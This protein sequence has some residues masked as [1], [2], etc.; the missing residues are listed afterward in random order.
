MNN[1]IPVR[2]FIDDANPKHE[3]EDLTYM[4]FLNFKQDKMNT[5]ISFY[6]SDFRGSSFSNCHFF[7]NNFDRADLI[8]C[9]LL[10]CS[11]F[12]VNIAASEI[13]NCYFKD[14]NFIENNY[15]HTSIQES[16]FENCEFTNEK[17]LLNA[18][19][20]TFINCKFI[21]CSFERSTTESLKFNNCEIFN[22]DLAT[23]HAERHNFVQCRIRNSSMGISYIFGYLFYNTDLN[24]IKILYRG[25]EI[26]LTKEAISHHARLL[27][28]E[29]RYHEFLNANIICHNLDA[30]PNMLKN[31]LE[32]LLNIN[33]YL[34]RLEV[35]NLFEV[36]QFYVQNNVIPCPIYLKT[37]EILET[38]D[39]KRF[40]S[41]ER[42]IYL[43]G[44][45][46]LKLF[47]I[48]GDYNNEFILSAL[49]SYSILVIHCRTNDYDTAKKNTYQFLNDLC[50][51]L[52]MSANFEFVD[53]KKGSWI[54]TFF[55]ITAL[56]LTIPKIISEAANVSFEINTKRQ[57]SK[58]L[59]AKLRKKNLT[60]DEL[61]TI[62]EIASNT[63]LIK[64][65]SY[66]IMPSNIL[67]ALKI[68]L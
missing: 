52:N 51:T 35:N 50:E 64:G 45:E 1:L 43:A 65:S 30:V 38:F 60:M 66:Q 28:A 55:I 9:V 16:T 25:E 39:W 56:A 21:S 61:K 5:P 4:S 32:A 8:S 67:D 62:S 54:F 31:I 15:N 37:L 68:Y 46:M 22:T 47:V 63:G 11:F 19:N 17:L 44:Y 48:D 6:R 40:T 49:D 20:C 14:T 24:D 29:Q 57:I 34:R 23:M 42:L 13:K 12:R 41:E 3:K 59:K 27:W 33:P 18:K 7:S 36:L 10:N 58:R 53:A 26:K 2:I